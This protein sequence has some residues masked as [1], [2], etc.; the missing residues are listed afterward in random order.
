MRHLKTLEWCRTPQGTKIH[1]RG[2]HVLKEKDESMQT[3]TSR[4]KSTEGKPHEVKS[5][6]LCTY[7]ALRLEE[8]LRIELESTY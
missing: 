1:L 3:S 7:C 2:C 5:R 4:R 6:I 8:S